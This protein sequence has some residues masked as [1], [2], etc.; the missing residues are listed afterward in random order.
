[1][2][3]KHTPGPWRVSKGRS[4]VWVKAGHQNV[5]GAYMGSYPARCGE[6]DLANA[7]LIAAAPELLDAAINALDYKSLDECLN[8]SKNP[9]EV[10]GIR[11][12]HL[13]ALRTAIAKATGGQS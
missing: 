11:F 2:G 12:E 5:A 4:V 10:W 13:K 6:Q 1:M 3:T 7:R 8:E 9:N